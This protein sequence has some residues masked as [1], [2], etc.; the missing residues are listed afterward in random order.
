MTSAVED[1]IFP[2]LDLDIATDLL[3]AG[4]ILGLET[5]NDNVSLSDNPPGDSNTR[6]G[7]EDDIPTPNSGSLSASR[8]PGSDTP[9]R[10]RREA[11]IRKSRRVRTG[12]LTCRERHLKCDE[13]LH[14]CQNCRKSGRVCR[15]GVRLN[16][17][18][19]QVVAP[20]HDLTPSPG[21][22]VTFRDESRHIASEYVGGFERYPP[23]M[24][25][26]QLDSGSLVSPPLSSRYNTTGVS[27]RSGSGM[28]QSDGLGYS[29][30]G[31]SI[32]TPQLLPDRRASFA[33]FKSAKQGRVGPSNACLSNPE[34]VFLV[35][36][37]VEE[38]GPWMDAMDEMKHFTNILPFHA[39][40]EPMLL[41]AFMA[42]GARHLF[43]VNPS[44][45]E[46][47]ASY[48][49][50]LASQDLLGL[51]QDPDRDSVL[52]ATAAVILNIY[53]SM[54]SRS[55]I[56]VHGMNHIAGA[57]ALIKECRW[58]ATSPGLGGA[59]F[60][61]NVSMELLSCLHFNWTLAW[62][63]DTWGVD[64]NMEQ[65]QP[66]VAGNEELWTHR[67]V[68]I[69]AKVTNFRSTFSHVHGLD[70][71]TAQIDQWYRDWCVYNEWCDQWANAVPRSMTPLG[72]LQPWQTNSKSVFPEI[73]L[74]KRSSIIARLFY[75]TA[76]ILL[77]K[78]H[79]L[80]SEFS[81]EMQSLQQSHAH[82]ICGIV[83]HT[84]DRGIST[85]C[86]RFLF[87]AASCL[88][89]RD[90]Q[91]EILNTIDRIK[92]TGCR[93]EHLKDELQE[94]WGWTLHPHSHGHD[95]A[96]GVE[97]DSLFGD[98]AFNPDPDPSSSIL[99]MHPAVVSNPLLAFADFE[100]ENHPYQ[101]FYVKPR[102]Q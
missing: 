66:S 74:I 46:G 26:P 15:R 38:V 98:H 7:E 58:D 55:M 42:C 24:V 82:D 70:H 41:K 45:G 40:E 63:P 57:R 19:T 14:R 35:Q 20:P 1:H 22:R 95:V 89:T 8:T 28:G 4:D 68:Y 76:R 83:A 67:M 78:I 90:A 84:K 23:P 56:S 16:F 32:S 47:K 79:P 64:M 13:A 60:W 54:T 39:L 99:K 59:C 62:D 21:H 3:G 48:F 5:S 96:V 72:Y 92:E 94:A 73:W 27:G 49:H 51:L 69:C 81:P 12:C 75:H 52:C 17:I 30:N 43:Q 6:E 2:A 77:T 61:L 50:D 37:F 93:V 97:V 53:E 80:E 91:D 31:R 86:T 102:E 87:I 29:P 100:M 101:G 65:T 10:R 85:L 18:D 11:V 71:S 9:R 33:P 88:A 34:E 44:Y 25:E 36:T